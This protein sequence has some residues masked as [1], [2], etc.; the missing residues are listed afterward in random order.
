MEEDEGGMEWEYGEVD[1]AQV[2]MVTMLR[3]DMECK[4]DQVS[5]GWRV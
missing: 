1:A 5:V 3:R 2:G 4:R